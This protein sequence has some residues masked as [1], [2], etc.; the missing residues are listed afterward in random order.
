[1]KPRILQPL[2][3]PGNKIMKKESKNTDYISLGKRIRKSRLSKHMTQRELAEKIG[4]SLSYIGLIE[5]GQRILSTTTL[6]KISI[7]FDCMTDELLR[8]SL[9]I[10]DDAYV[11]LPDIQR[12]RL[13]AIKGFST[14][15]VDKLE[16]DIK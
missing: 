8:D 7:A 11:P 5:N 4:V 16:E 2:L 3:K 14:F 1:M 9:D 15:I 12:S 10:Y 13:N 6:V